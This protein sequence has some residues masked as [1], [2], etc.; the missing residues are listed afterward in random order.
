MYSKSR[1]LKNPAFW[2]FDVEKPSFSARI[3]LLDVLQL[4]DRPDSARVLAWDLGV[5]E[6]GLR[7]LHVQIN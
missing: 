6:L 5:R 4:V 1:K 2:R 3:A 7:V